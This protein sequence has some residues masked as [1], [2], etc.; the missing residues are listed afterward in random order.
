MNGEAI[1]A[2]AVA[3]AGAGAPVDPPEA[4]AAIAD[5]I[6]RIGADRGATAVEADGQTTRATRP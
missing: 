2:R 3:G 1:A 4:G 6:A 5:H